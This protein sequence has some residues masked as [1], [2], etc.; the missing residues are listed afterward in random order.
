MA[1]PV[2]VYWDAC[3]WIAYINE[4]RA[5]PKDDRTGENRFSMCKAVLKSAQAGDVEIVTSA[6]TLAEVCKS[7]EARNESL[8]R[9]PTF[10]DHEFILVVAVDKN[11]GIK[12]QSIQLSGMTGIKPPD[13]VH[14]ATAQRA[15]VREFHTF[16]DSLLK[17]DGQINAVNGHVIK[18][19]KPGE[20]YQEGT[21]FE[22]E[23]K[24]D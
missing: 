4:E 1:K 19:C 17:K 7:E 23:D 6:L 21:L 10:L 22:G 2:R 16:D 20:G 3:T 5:T 11:I 15:N 18:C 14:L 8:G 24:E 9:L 13:A 12:A